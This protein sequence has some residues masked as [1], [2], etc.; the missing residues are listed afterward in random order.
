MLA[1][2]RVFGGEESSAAPADL[3]NLP[4]STS[5][6]VGSCFSCGW[7]IDDNVNGKMVT[8]GIMQG[9]LSAP[10]EDRIQC[11]PRNTWQQEFSLAAAAG[12]GAI[13]WIYDTFGD[14]ANPIET[15]E[16]I[17]Q[18]KWLSAEHGIS[19]ESI[20]ADW[21]MEEPLVGVS[22]GESKTAFER[23]EWLI[24][25]AGLLGMGRIVL[26][27]VDSSALKSDSLISEA[28]RMLIKILPLAR[29]S[30]IEIHLETSLDPSNFGAL[31]ERIP[32]PI[33]RVNYDIGNSASCGYDP[34]EEFGMYGQRIGSIHIKD[35]LLHGTTVPLGTGD[36]DFVAVFDELYKLR[37]VGPFVLQTA[38]GKPGDEVGHTVRNVEIAK[39]LFAAGQPAQVQP[40]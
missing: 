24:G 20:C 19:V 5:L 26:P 38:R 23:L 15:D 21:F 8:F 28:E 7:R 18:M 11:F 10:L 22:Q 29:E 30:G 6:L 16:G 4:V 32:D 33:V 17:S 35:R 13:E 36:A 27:F 9:R 1:S 34:R 3:K 31:L 25:R 2:C 14:S 40:T 39:S 37:Y 12:L